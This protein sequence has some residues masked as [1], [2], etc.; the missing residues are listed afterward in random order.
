MC[1]VSFVPEDHES[2]M[3]YQTLNKSVVE[4]D[5]LKILWTSY[6]LNKYCIN[7]NG[8]SS[9]TSGIIPTAFKTA[10]QATP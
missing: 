2:G 6:R 7:Y 8:D 10:S 1:H 4:W 3:S 5:L 9:L